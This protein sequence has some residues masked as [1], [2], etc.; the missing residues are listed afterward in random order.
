MG[1]QVPYRMDTEMQAETTVWSDSQAPWGTIPQACE[2]Q[3]KSDCAGAF[4]PRP[5]A[6]ADSEPPK[7]SVA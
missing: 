1:M 6:H 2:A 5:R 4:V 7:Y 3:G